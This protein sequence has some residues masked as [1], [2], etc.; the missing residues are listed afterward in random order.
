MWAEK[1][2]EKILVTEEQI[3][4]K[5]AELGRQITEVPFRFSRNWPSV[6]ILTSSMISWTSQVMSADIPAVKSAS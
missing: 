3:T 1:D 6:L 2:V 5:A 4:A